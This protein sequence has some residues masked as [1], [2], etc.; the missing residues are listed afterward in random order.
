MDFI[1]KEYINHALCKDALKT[2]FG[3]SIDTQSQF[4]ID[5]ID[6]LIAEN[7]IKIYD[8]FNKCLDSHNLPIKKNKII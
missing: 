7:K 6:N 3:S 2:K 4:T 1:G 5:W 8:A